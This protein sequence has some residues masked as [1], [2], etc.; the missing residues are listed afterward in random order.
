MTL[1]ILFRFHFKTGVQ[2][3]PSAEAKS[4]GVSNREEF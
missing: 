4:E 1:L 2:K 3:T